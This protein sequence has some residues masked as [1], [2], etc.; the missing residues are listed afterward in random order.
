[1]HNRRDGHQILGSFLHAF[2][3]DFVVYDNQMDAGDDI[4][5]TTTLGGGNVVIHNAN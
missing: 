3:G 2:T 5:P 1:L 4:E